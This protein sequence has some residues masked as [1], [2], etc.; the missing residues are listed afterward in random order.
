MR[1]PPDPPPG[2][3]AADPRDWTRAWRRV[4]AS[5]SVK[6]VGYACADW[7]DYE[8]G[9]EIHPGNAVLMMACGLTKKTVIGGLAQ[10]R[11]WRLVWRYLE[12][13]K[14]G[15]AALSDVYRLT[16]P[17]DISAIPMYSPDWEP[18]KLAP[19]ENARIRCTH[20]TCSRLDHP[21][22]QVYSLH[23]I[24]PE[25][26]YSVHPTH[27]KN[28][29]YGGVVT[30][31]N[32]KLRRRP[33]PIAKAGATVIHRRELRFRFIDWRQP[34]MTSSWGCFD[35]GDP[36]HWAG[37]CWTRKP[38]TSQGHHDARIATYRLWCTDARRVTPY[39]KQKLIERE[40]KMWADVQ[41]ERKS[42]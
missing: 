40:N 35:C 23:L 11:D 30:H 39:Q 28:T 33:W 14:N 20:Y 16:F 42:A 21:V 22:Y 38:P 8:T 34:E 5:P 19:V 41:K 18:P 27:T 6:L 1:R 17:D 36:L 10:L 25:Q 4:I 29:T 26:V 15:R 13:S 12:G 7:A 2:L 24:G 37:Q 3:T 31:P 9:A 32:S